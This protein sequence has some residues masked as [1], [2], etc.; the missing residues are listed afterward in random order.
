M[1][2]T[3][4]SLPGV[5]GFLGAFIYAAP[6]LS[7]CM[8]AAREAG[9]GGWRCIFDFVTSLAIGAIAAA[10]FT[11][12]ALRFLGE[13]ATDQHNAIAALVG[14]MANPTAPRLVD[15]FSALA[16]NVLSEKLLKLFKGD[17]K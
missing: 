9:A 4:F 10:A 13:A 8:Y 12:W 7:A 14:L 16:S 6:R 15:V 5:W 1:W 2:E 17:P 3:I 11:P